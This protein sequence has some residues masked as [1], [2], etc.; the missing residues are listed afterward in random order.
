MA[1]NE[2][3][4]TQLTDAQRKQ[5]EAELEQHLQSASTLIQKLGWSKSDFLVAMKI[6]FFSDL[7]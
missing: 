6:Q 1:T 5:V 4:P 2:E 3:N 7:K